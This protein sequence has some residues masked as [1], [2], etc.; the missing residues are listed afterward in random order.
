MAGVAAV[1]FRAGLRLCGFGGVATW[2][3]G[4][5]STE[6]RFPTQS[7]AWIV[8]GKIPARDGSG[9]ETV[10]QPPPTESRRT[11]PSAE[12]RTVEGFET[13]K[14]TAPTP[15]LRELE[16]RRL[17]REPGELRRRRREAVV[18]AGERLR[19]ARTT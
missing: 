12:M 15:A 2:T 3:I 11:P 19:G 7:V 9:H 16:Q 4:S 1:I 8:T 14:V 6:A 18:A 10:C 13:Q 17:R 5:A